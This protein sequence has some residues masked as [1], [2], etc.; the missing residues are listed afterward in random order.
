MLCSK[1]RETLWL[2]RNMF[3]T[4]RDLPKCAYRSVVVNVYLLW[5]E[6][7]GTESAR[8]KKIYNFHKTNYF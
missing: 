3:W 4:H 1:S 5:G 8:D 7:A 2:L 6:V